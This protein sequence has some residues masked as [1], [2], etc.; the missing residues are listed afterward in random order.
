M[1]LRFTPELIEEVKARADIVAIVSEHVALRRSGK[2]YVGLCPFHAEKTP[3]FTVSPDKQMFHC[4]GCQAGGDVITFVMRITGSDF[5]TAMERL[6]R[7]VGV[8]VSRYVASPDELE[9]MRERQ[10][11]QEALRLA[12]VFFANMLR[13]RRDKPRGR[14]CST[15]ASVPPPCSGFNWAT[16]RRATRCGAFFK[17]GASTTRWPSRPA[18]WCR[19]RREKR[20]TRV[21]ATGSCSRF[22]TTP[23]AS[24]ASVAGC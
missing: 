21:F 22:G 5:P 6:A 2:N 12:A 19:A 18:F 14:T 13:S 8:D 4:F 15:G 1:A 16:R 3:S 20:P 24:S 7:R 17:N 9:R 10:R 11:L 23:G